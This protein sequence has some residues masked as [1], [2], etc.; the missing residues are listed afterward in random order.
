MKWV[1]KNID[2]FHDTFLFFRCT[3]SHEDEYVSISA[4]NYLYSYIIIPATIKSQQCM[5]NYWWLSIQFVSLLFYTHAHRHYFIYDIFVRCNKSSDAP[6]TKDNT[7]FNLSDKKCELQSR[8][9]LT[10]VSVQ[11]AHFISFNHSCR[12]CFVWQRQQV[13]ITISNWSLY[14]IDSSTQHPNKMIF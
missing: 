9:F 5:Y 6:I 11:S 10:I 14:Y 7:L 4:G 3:C 2:I 13:C 12:L 1:T 8:A